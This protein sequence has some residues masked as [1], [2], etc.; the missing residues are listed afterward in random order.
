LRELK[1]LAPEQLRAGASATHGTL[2]LK[3]FDAHGS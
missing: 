3:L 1:A 2:A